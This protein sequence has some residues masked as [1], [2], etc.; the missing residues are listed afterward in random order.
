MQIIIANHSCLAFDTLVNVNLP[1]RSNPA[2]VIL[3]ILMKVRYERFHPLTLRLFLCKGNAGKCQWSCPVKNLSVII[4]WC[5]CY[6][7]Q[8][9]RPVIPAAR[10][11]PA[12]FS[13][14]VSK[15]QELLPRANPT[16]LFRY[17]SQ[18]NKATK[19]LTSLL[20]EFYIFFHFRKNYYVLLLC[21]VW[22]YIIKIS[23]TI[24]W[25]EYPCPRLN[26]WEGA[27]TTNLPFLLIH[28]S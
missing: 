26:H 19:L 25:H 2:L 1:V 4:Q 18:L 13:L 16:G 27:G 3:T 21:V 6:P 7:F 12:L 9:L 14:P 5:R 11:G 15:F 17:I 8:Q 10:T 22:H 28:P 23:A 24:F 20:T